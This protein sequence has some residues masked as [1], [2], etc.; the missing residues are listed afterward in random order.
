VKSALDLLLGRKIWLLLE[1]SGC[2]SIVK[3]LML[4]EIWSRVWG[5][6]SREFGRGAESRFLTAPSSRFG[7]TSRGV[8]RVIG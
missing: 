4:L 5:E 6:K 3:E 1:L 7:M 2:Y 8:V